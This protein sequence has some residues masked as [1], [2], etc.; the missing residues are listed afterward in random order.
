ML[1]LTLFYDS[2]RISKSFGKEIAHA[3][4]NGHI[5]CEFWT[6]IDPGGSRTYSRPI[7]MWDNYTIT[8]SQVARLC[9]EIIASFRCYSLVECA[10]FKPS[11]CHCAYKY[12]LAMAENR[13][14]RG[15]PKG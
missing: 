8:T 14:G 3:A 15:L 5:S 2:E 11:A 10:R 7:S 6:S 1:A 9:I 4:W 12:I 13:S